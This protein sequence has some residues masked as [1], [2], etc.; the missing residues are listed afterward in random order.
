M[1]HRD[2]ARRRSAGVG[3]GQLAARRQQ[4]HRALPAAA[5][6]RRLGA[7]RRRDRPRPLLRR[8]TV[9]AGAG[10]PGHRRV[11]L[12]HRRTDR[13]G[14]PAAPRRCDPI[15]RQRHQRRPGHPR[16][17]GPAARRA[18]ALAGAGRR[19]PGGR[20][21]RAG[22]RRGHALPGVHEHRR[23]RRPG[24][25]PL[26][27]RRQ[28]RGAAGDGLQRRLRAGR[29]RHL[30]SRRP[31][32]RH[33]QCRVVAEARR[34]PRGRGDGGLRV[35]RPGAGAQALPGPRLGHHRQ[36][37]RPARAAQAA[38]AAS[39]QR[40][41]AVPRRPGRRRVRGDGRP[42]RRARRSPAC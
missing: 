25:D 11:V 29:R 16:Q 4:R 23:R 38:E 12:R 33:P 2:R 35:H 31:R 21:R 13:S 22:H 40:P 20:T 42:P 14:Q 28:R 8:R 39:G 27:L 17:P 6:P 30:R 18:P 5:G 7:H 3:L 32:D 37:R 19:R 1:R 34:R 9:A 10:R 15:Q 26:R 41:G 36:P 24:A